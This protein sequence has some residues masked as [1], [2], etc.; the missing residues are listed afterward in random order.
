MK[1]KNELKLRAFSLTKLLAVLIVMLMLLVLPRFISLITR[2]K[3]TEARLLVQFSQSLPYL[4]IAM[5]LISELNQ[6][7]PKSY[8]QQLIESLEKDPEQILIF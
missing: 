2:V 6:K 7:S 8:V 3:S 4:D 5:E 1:S